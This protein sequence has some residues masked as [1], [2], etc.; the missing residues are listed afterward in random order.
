VT[1]VSKL[2]LTHIFYKLVGDSPKEFED[3]NVLITDEK[4]NKLPISSKDINR[5]L[6]KNFRAMF[7]K[8]VKP[9]QR[10]VLTMEYDWEEPERVFS[11]TFSSKCKEFKYLFSIPKGVQIN[12]RV[13]KIDPELGEKRYAD[14]PQVVKS[15]PNK[16]QITW[17]TSNLKA[18]D[19]YE[20][21]W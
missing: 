15:L 21:R 8:P 2:P 7:L 19:T 20:F 12:D 6:E 4:G 5:P 18:N 10:K 1:N 3:M 9:K 13:L 17:Q 16:T 11:Y 14:H